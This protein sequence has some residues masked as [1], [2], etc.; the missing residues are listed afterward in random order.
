MTRMP[1]SSRSRNVEL[2]VAQAIV[3]F[4]S[5][6]WSERDGR[7]QRLI[8]RIFGIFGHGNVVGLGEALE[9]Y[10]TDLTYHQAKNE[11]MMV[12]AASGYAKA[13]RRL[14]T[15]A[16]AASIGPGS[17]NMLTGAAC[18]TANRLPVLLFPSDLFATRAQGVVLQ[19]VEPSW[20]GDI[21]VNDA[22]RPVSRYFDRI[23]R[24]EKLIPALPAAMRA[25]VDQAET[26]AVTL[27]LPQD[28]QGE[29]FS[30]PAQ[31][32][33]PR[34]WRVVRRPP[35]REE[36]AAAVE[37]IRRAERPLLIAGG[38]V[39]Y[40]EAEAALEAFC[41]AT[42]I[43]V[44]ETHAGKGLAPMRDL[45]LGTIG[46]NGTGAANAIARAADLVICVGTRLTDFITGSNSLFQND[47]VRFVGINTN[48]ADAAKMSATT[49]VADARESLAALTEALRTAGYR[50]PAPVAATVSG[51]VNTWR[52]AVE[53][54]MAPVAGGMMTQ[55]EVVVAL[56]K[57][58][59]PDD[60]VVTA[61]GSVIT[62]V[63]RL[64]DCEGHAACA[65][66]FGYS[67]MGFD[68]P[69]AIG[70]RMAKGKAGEIYVAIGDG[71]YLLANSELVTAV[72]E[73]IK[74]TLVL[75]ENQGFQSI[76]ALQ[77][78]KT[79]VSFGNERRK[80]NAA[81]NRLDA[82]VASVDFEAHARSLGCHATTVDSVAGLEAAL[83]DALQVAD[84][85]VVIVAR[86]DP[87]RLFAA[88]NGCW[89]DVGVSLTS[90]LGRVN[91]ATEQH[92]QN[93]RSLQRAYL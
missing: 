28:V 42:G 85:P 34:V 74:M 11:E 27:S 46:V 20:S 69:S 44:A 8:P 49:I 15:F 3:R 89:W 2:T 93:R 76:H 30:Y 62:D 61:A 78:G 63:T 1:S 32:F 25:L 65:I 26:G 70:L 16:C 92:V 91:Q 82:D 84:R 10:G 77:R 37:A 53:K 64:W 12:H 55:A 5:V 19:Q 38:G 75:I 41:R 88:D 79:G 83:T 48:G 4:L 57:F 29:A 17:T 24:P 50:A 39:R 80:R 60:I 43:P 66:E 31:L 54:E 13:S 73:G 72:Q 22:F 14:S 58:S 35:A 6:Q 21:S 87:T 81:T 40:S 52:G 18:A 23:E 68:I 67:C 9:E 33:E 56:N 86:V 59:R 36:I 71:N 45:A 47:D 7:R 51:A 90:G